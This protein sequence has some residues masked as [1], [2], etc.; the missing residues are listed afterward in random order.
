MRKFHL[1]DLTKNQIVFNISIWLILIILLAFSISLENSINIFGPVIPA[2]YI[3]FYLVNK[4]YKQKKYVFYVLTSLTTLFIFGMISNEIFEGNYTVITT[5]EETTLVS[6]FYF[7]PYY[8]P[9]FNPFIGIVIA[10]LASYL[11]K[12]Q[13][14]EIQEIKT[15]KIKTELE[16]LKSQ[17]NPHFFFNTLNTLYSMVMM[18]GDEETAEGISQLS[19][20]MRYMIYDT[21]VDLISLDKETEHIKNFIELQKLRFDQEDE[22]DVKFE[23]FGET[24]S[25]TVPPMLFIP[26]VENAYK[27]GLSTK[28]KNEIFI[29]VDALD[30]LL[31]FRIMNTINNKRKSNPE[32][33]GIG[34]ENVKKR[35]EILFPQ[36]HILRTSQDSKF[37]NV[38]LSFPINN[39]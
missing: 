31:K 27:H 38:Y 20:L 16:L 15:Q 7:S 26:F 9:F 14:L 1:K 37:F 4:F 39:A 17:V 5:I 34:I 35:L 25:K 18:K 22:L 13:K 33:S 24:K 2:I 29:Q 19:G 10:S 12:K 11:N 3:H 30:D 8:E 32:H 28:Q 6:P 23:I 36:T 21:K